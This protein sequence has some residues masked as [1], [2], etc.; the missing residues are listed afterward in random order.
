MLYNDLR[1]W[2]EKVDEFGE[3]RRVEGVDWKYEMGAVT[4]VY[5][6]N[7]PY[8]AILFDNIKDYPA[9][10]RVLVGVHHQSL[11]RQCLTTHLPLDYDR[12]QFIQA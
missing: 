11:K 9:G 8:S 4:E 3:L 12:N 6:R 7:P 1:E 10:H 5:A 2:I